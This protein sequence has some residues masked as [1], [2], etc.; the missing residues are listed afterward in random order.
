MQKAFWQF[1]NLYTGQELV[2]GMPSYVVFANGQWQGLLMGEYVDDLREIIEHHADWRPRD[3]AEQDASWQQIVPFGVFRVGDKYAEL[4]RGTEG[5]HSRLYQK[6]TLGVGGHVIDKEYEQSK[7]LEMWIEQKFHEE[8]HY[9]GQITVDFL[10][11]INDNS[12]AIGKHHLGIVYLLTGNV[13]EFKAKKH[14]E[15]RM[16]KLS[17]IT[18]EDLE[19]LDRWSQMIYRQL[20]ESEALG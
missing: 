4:K 16:V 1:G 10:G 17:E 20:R 18:S 15:S 13:E 11:I 14:T 9:D 2:M 12:D 8:M 5:S 19:F 6:Y 7:S 3:E